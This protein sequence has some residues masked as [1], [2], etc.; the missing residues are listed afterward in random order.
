MFSI[1]VEDTQ[2]RDNECK[3]KLY[4]HAVMLHSTFNIFGL[5]LSI[6]M[7]GLTGV[8]ERGPEPQRSVYC[9]SIASYRM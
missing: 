5:I 2:K 6:P 9:K 3:E 4:D 8:K 7:H 1:L